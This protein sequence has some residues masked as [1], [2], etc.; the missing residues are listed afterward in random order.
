[1]LEDGKKIMPD[2][3][4]KAKKF[5]NSFDAKCQDKAAVQLRLNKLLM[6]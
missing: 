1:M 5:C 2:R 6:D 3:Y 4:K